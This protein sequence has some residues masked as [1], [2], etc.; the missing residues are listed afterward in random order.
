[1]SW[2]RGSVARMTAL[3][4]SPP[5]RV[6]APTEAETLYPGS[7]AEISSLKISTIYRAPGGGW[8]RAHLV[9]ET[10]DGRTLTWLDGQV[11]GIKLWCS[12][13]TVAPWG[14]TQHGSPEWLR[15]RLASDARKAVVA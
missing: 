12:L 15:E 4:I 14:A 11:D 9:A 6:L 13:W 10:A 3:P 1:V 2:L 7:T 5:L 8:S